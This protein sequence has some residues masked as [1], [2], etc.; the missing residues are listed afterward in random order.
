M[1]TSKLFHPP[2]TID[3]SFYF[4]GP[5]IEER[6][7][8]DK[9]N[10]KKDKNKKLIYISLGIVFMENSELFQKCIKAFGNVKEYQ[11]IL[12]I[13]RFVDIHQFGN[14]PDNIYAFNFVP[15]IQVLKQADIF[16]TH[17]GINSIN[18]A[19]LLF[20][21]PLIIIPQA[22]DQYDNAHQIEKYK[23][24]ITLDKNNI[25]E[26]ILKNAVINFLEKKEVYKKGVDIIVESFKEARKERKKI[27]EN[28][29]V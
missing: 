23:A 5:S 17:G 1:L 25:T 11:V 7:V 4:I 2:E 21:L 28:L 12:S 15:Q 26:E 3:D 6:P 16:I 8:D 27:Y 18:E 13:G 10:F 9:F 19:M 14:L 20:N 24:G 22:L 29:L